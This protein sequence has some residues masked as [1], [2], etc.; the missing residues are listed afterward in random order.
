MEL[1]NLQ[2][3]IAEP[4]HTILQVDVTARFKELLRHGRITVIDSVVKRRPPFLCPKVMLQR[5]AM[6]C[7]AL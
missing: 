3:S 5:D 7:I 1:S 2:G 6:R 4:E